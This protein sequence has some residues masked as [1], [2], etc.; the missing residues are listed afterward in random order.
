M[1]EKLEQINARPKPFEFYT[2]KELWT[3]GHTSKQMLD[4]HLNESVDLS[5]RKTESIDR[6]VDWMVSRFGLGEGSAVADFG[7][8]PG[9]YTS[10]LAERGAAVTGIDFS[11]RSIAYAREA[12]A[13]KGLEVEYVCQ[14]YLTFESDKRFD[15]ITLIFCDLCPLSPD[16]RKNLLS[17]FFKLL[18]DD[19]SVLL[20]V[21]SL[22]AFDKREEAATHELSR[23]IGFWSPDPYYG[24]VNTFKYE[25]ELEDAGFV[26]EAFHGDVAGAEFR[27]EADEFAIVAKT[28]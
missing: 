8:G 24:F 9:L 14:D 28:D 15:L 4:Y 20:D 16:Q 10:R 12:A 18:K 17:R 2:A 7:C 13:E 21:A 19:G 23:L 1:F 25:E 22:N 27:P 5:S 26:V 6:S 3:N 11:E